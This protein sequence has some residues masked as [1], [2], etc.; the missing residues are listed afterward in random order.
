LSDVRVYVVDD[1]PVVLVGL[2]TALARQ[3][4]IDVVGGAPSGEV[5][6][7]E[8]RT[9]AADVVLVDACLPGMSGP[10]V[11]AALRSTVPAARCLVLTGTVD[12]Y[13]LRAAIDAEARGFVVKDVRVPDLAD[14]IR[15]VHAGEIVLDPRATGMVVAQFRTPDRPPVALTPREQEI[16]EFLAAGLSNPAIARRLRISPSTAKSYVSRLLVKLDVTTR[17]AAV[18]RAAELGLLAPAVPAS[19]WQVR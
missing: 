9:L 16:V 2:Q 11:V 6:L 5:A 14:A 13:L 17:T 1:H 15:R 7:A 10:D 3:E 18:A 12:K 19:P 8:L 4:G